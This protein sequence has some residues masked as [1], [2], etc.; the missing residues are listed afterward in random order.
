[1]GY[2]MDLANAARRH[3]EAANILGAEAL[4]RGRPDVAA[5][6]YGVAGECALKELMRLSGMKPMD[7]TDK[8]AD[9]FF[10]HF[11]E[12]KA[13]LRDTARGRRHARL[14]VHAQNSDLFNGWDVKM[15]YAPS[16]DVMKQPRDTWATQAK[17]LVEEM[18]GHS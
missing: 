4:P 17:Q 7:P 10:L 3:L 2:G 6:L 15:R 8:K 5:Y 14:L 18:G 9:P 16:A 13:A 1:M 12:L 11:P